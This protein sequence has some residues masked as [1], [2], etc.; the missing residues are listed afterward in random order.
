MAANCG[1]KGPGHN[2]A[3]DLVV[4]HW[5]Q[6]WRE[7]GNTLGEGDRHCGRPRIASR[8]WSRGFVCKCNIGSK[9][10]VSNLKLYTLYN[11]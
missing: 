11:V 7:S 3:L 9:I 8:E 4:K 10:S 2:M 6:Q 1:V 5:L